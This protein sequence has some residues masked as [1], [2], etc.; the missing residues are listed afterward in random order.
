[1]VAFWNVAVMNCIQPVNWEACTPVHEWL[2]PDLIEGY[3][4]YTGDTHPY[5]TEKDYLNNNISSP[6]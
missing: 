4:L 3:K 6:R 5:Q 1:L 2:V